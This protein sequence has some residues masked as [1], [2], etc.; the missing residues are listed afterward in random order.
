MIKIFLEKF[1]NGEMAKNSLIALF[2]KVFGV[3]LLFALTLFMT[4]NFSTETV[5]QYGFVRSVL[6]I[7]G[8]FSVVGTEQSVIY[9]MGYL[10]SKNAENNIKVIYI[11]SL[12]LIFYACL[13]LLLLVFL[14]NKDFVNSNFEVSNP[15]ELI[16]KVII[17]LF[18]YSIM[19]LNIGVFRALNKMILSETYRNILVYLL[20][21]GVIYFLLINNLENWVVDAFLGAY[22]VLGIISTIQVYFMLK[23]LGNLNLDIQTSTKSIFVISYPMALNT[24]TYFILQSVGVILLGKFES[25]ESVAYYDTAVRVASLTALGVMSV[26]IAI[27]PKLAEDYNRGNF[28][29]L[30]K[31]YKSAIRMMIALSLPAVLVL[32]L[33]ADFVLGLFG[34]EYRIGK[35]ALYILVAA[36]FLTTF[37]GISGTYMNMTAKQNILNRILIFACILNVL[38]NYLL[39]PKYGLNGSA[40]AAGL[41]MLAWNI[42]AATYIYKKDRIS[43][44]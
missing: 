9:Y 12:K 19:M 39:I 27:A 21:F 20:F 6:L 2:L 34:P 4:N 25:F 17:Y 44:F 26:N 42:I 30:K 29:E 37:M 35:T 13:I 1:K 36:Q 24:M 15:Y 38:L 18:L 14:I 10:K 31:T 40:F 11:K 28:A 7:L 41:S 33:F 23:K 5:G 3:G 43:L 32:F 16:K 8:G 22:A